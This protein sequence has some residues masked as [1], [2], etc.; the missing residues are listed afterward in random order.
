MTIQ[1]GEFRKSKRF[2]KG[3][4]GAGPGILAKGLD[5]K[6]VSHRNRFVSAGW[7]KLHQIIVFKRCR[8]NWLWTGWKVD[9]FRTT[10]LFLKYFWKNDWETAILDI[11]ALG[12]FGR[13]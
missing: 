9:S 4:I 1:V 11:N 7:S 5:L 8:E 2:P 10:N 12:D 13:L 3:K 6:T